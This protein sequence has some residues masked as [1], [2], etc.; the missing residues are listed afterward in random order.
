MVTFKKNT[1]IEDLIEAFPGAIPLLSKYGI[2]C[3]ICGEPS[4]G[5]IEEAANEKGIEEKQLKDIITIINKEFEISKGKNPF[6]R[7]P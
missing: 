5:T 2:R 6:C 4:W 7:K 1:V 3:L